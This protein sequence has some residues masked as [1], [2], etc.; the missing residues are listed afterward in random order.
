[1]SFSSTGLIYSYDCA[2]IRSQPAKAHHRLQAPPHRRQ[3]PPPRQPR[4]NDDEHDHRTAHPGEA[5]GEP[6]PFHPFFPTS[7]HLLPRRPVIKASQWIQIQHPHL[8][9]VVD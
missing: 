6:A 5:V 4:P 7:P 3:G 9:Q 8:S 1:M 2:A